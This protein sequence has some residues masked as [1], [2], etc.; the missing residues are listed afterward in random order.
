MMPS[1]GGQ[2]IARLPVRD[3]KSG[4][5]HVIVETPK[6]S[7]AKFDYDEERGLFRLA[8]MLPQGSTFPFSFGFIPST[9]A[10]DGDPVDVLILMEEPA[11]T[12]CL[13]LCRLLGVI[14]A[15]QTEESG[16]TTRNDR[17]I[18]VAAHS[19]EH[20]DLESVKHLPKVLIREIEHFF[21]S[22]NEVRGKR[23]RPLGCYGPRRAEKLVEAGERRRRR[24][25]KT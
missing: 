23:F 18:A 15:E 9:R 7:G 2:P 11:F 1:K 14:E 6:G 19:R 3:R 20:A 13:V 24:A 16:E 22:Y 25:S 4:A 10:P 5:L 12:G 17:L 8:G 21:V